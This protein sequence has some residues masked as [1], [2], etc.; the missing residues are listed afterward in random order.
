MARGGKEFIVVSE[1][2]VLEKDSSHP[3]GTF[4]TNEL[5]W[6]DI[7]SCWPKRS[8]KKYTLGW[9]CAYFDPMTV[10]RLITGRY[11]IISALL[12][13]F[14]WNLFLEFLYHDVST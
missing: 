2:V 8:E 4:P 7:F 10:F 11:V 9:A 6:S 5:L 12:S 3:T 1:A 14:S 13:I